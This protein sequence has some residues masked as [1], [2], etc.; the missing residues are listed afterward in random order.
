MSLNFQL[1]P[2][3][4]CFAEVEWLQIEHSAAA[5][6]LWYLGQAA[7]I[8]LPCAEAYQLHSFQLST[9]SSWCVLAKESLCIGDGSGDI[10]H[11]GNSGDC[12]ICCLQT[13]EQ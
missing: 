7:L 10:L 9:W 1:A 8:Q 13:A 2:V 6:K 11:I 4:F 12:E 5:R 3:Q